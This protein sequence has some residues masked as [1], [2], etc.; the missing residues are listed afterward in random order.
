MNY[1][2][3]KAMVD[4][5]STDWIQRSL[6]W[7]ERWTLL[8][9]VGVH[10]TWAALRYWIT[11]MAV[12]LTC[13]FLATFGVVA[14]WLG[15]AYALGKQVYKRSGESFYDLMPMRVWSLTKQRYLAIAESTTEE[16]GSLEI[17]QSHS[18]EQQESA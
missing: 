8:F 5:S 10:L 11:L 4:E 2:T 16:S 6:S 18:S 9:V 1:Q 13:I 14:L 12:I 15:T 17:Y 7:R 3:A